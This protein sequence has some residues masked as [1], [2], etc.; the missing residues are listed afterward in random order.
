M[1]LTGDQGS[2]KVLKVDC[3]ICLIK[4]FTYAFHPSPL[5][6]LNLCIY[7]LYLDQF[8][9]QNTSIQYIK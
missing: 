1:S 2:A 4:S 6:S 9:L 5:H 7:K 3:E 8:D